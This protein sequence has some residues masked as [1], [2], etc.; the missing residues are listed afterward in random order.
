MRIFSIV[1]LSFLIFFSCSDDSDNPMESSCGSPTD[2]ELI[3]YSLL[4]K[5]ELG[6][7]SGSNETE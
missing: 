7:N 2:F 6:W 3:E 5:V 4:S 1:M